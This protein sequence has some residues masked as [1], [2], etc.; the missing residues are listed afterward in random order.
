LDDEPQIG[1]VVCKF[2]AMIDYGAQQFSDPN[3]FLA[4]LKKQGPELVVLDLALGES[5]AIDII[6][7]LETLKYRGKVLLI[8]GR[9]EGTLREIER[10]GRSRGLTMLPPLQK[11]FRLPDLKASVSAPVETVSREHADD[12]ANKKTL[13]AD[14]RVLHE[15]LQHDL[16]DLWYQPKIDLKTM[17]VCGAE[18]LVRAR[19]PTLGI[20]APLELLPEADDPLY[21]PLSRFVVRRALNDW[22]AFA[23]QGLPL[24][25]SVNIPSS[26]LHAPG[27]VDM[28]RQ[29]V[30]RDRAFPGLIIEI[31]QDEIIRDPAWIYEVST[32][33]TLYNVWISIDNFGSA[34]ASLSRLKDLPFVELKLDR[35]FVS[36]CATDELKRGVCETMVDLARRFGASLCAGGVEAA[37]DLL[38]IRDLGFD[39]AQG[40]LLG[41]PMP[42]NRLAA[43]V[44]QL[45]QPSNAAALAH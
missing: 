34:Y 29:M 18:A 8:S 39:T 14:A 25:L 11:P 9:D 20:I 43:F 15:A 37:E 21:L 45:G 3:R 26:V 42:A 40:V 27:F 5:D 4:E 10:I 19:H 30:P 22:A 7:Q 36:S 31:T 16:L 23:D 38:C 1:A 12:E 44:E 24:K 41:T 35:S 13:L 33:L 2:L 6:R 28:V 17:A 32:Q